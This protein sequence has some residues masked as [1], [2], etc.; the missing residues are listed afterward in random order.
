MINRVRYRTAQ[1]FSAI[2]A[3]V[4]PADSNLAQSVLGKDTSEFALFQQMSLTDQRHAIAVL[5][6]LIE[7]GNTDIALQKAALLHDVGKSMGQP[8][9]YRILVVILQKC[10]PPVLRKL[11]DAPLD[12][13]KWRQAFVVNYHHPKIGADMAKKAGCETLVVKLIAAHQNIPKNNPT[14]Q[15]EQF[16]TALYAADNK[17]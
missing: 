15:M 8:I 3:N 13:P 9:V 16:H 17:N 2:N 4:T 10:C 12:S 5:K 1:F 7:H 6:T 11:A 14:T